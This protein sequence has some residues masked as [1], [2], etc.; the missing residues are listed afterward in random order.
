MEPANY[1]V[2]LDSM[3]WKRSMNIEYLVQVT[4]FFDPSFRRHTCASIKS[5]FKCRVNQMDKLLFMWLV[6]FYQHASINMKEF[7]QYHPMQSFAICTWDFLS[8]IIEFQQLEHTLCVLYMKSNNW[9]VRV[10]CIRLY[11][12]HM[13]FIANR[14]VTSQRVHVPMCHALASYCDFLDVRRNLF[15]SGASWKKSHKWARWR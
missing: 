4:F 9:L 6:H 14:G 13:A 7:F 1:V 10:H 2:Q 5:H 11:I 8:S 15:E 12:I 3:K